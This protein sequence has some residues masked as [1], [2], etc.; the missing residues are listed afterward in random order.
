MR[1]STP[2]EYRCSSTSKYF[3]ISRFFIRRSTTS[4]PINSSEKNAVSCV[5]T[6]HRCP[7]VL[8]YRRLEVDLRPKAEEKRRVCPF[9]ERIKD[10]KIRRDLTPTG[11]LHVVVEFDAVFVL[12]RKQVRSEAFQ[13]I[14]YTDVKITDTESVRF[15]YRE[16]AASTDA[17]TAKPIDWAWVA[18]R[19]S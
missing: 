4:R 15:P 12:Q 5:I 10:L 3:A 14:A 17:S 7:P 6:F 16:W 19:D 11:R 18:I 9:S 8:G 2:P 13:R 1:F